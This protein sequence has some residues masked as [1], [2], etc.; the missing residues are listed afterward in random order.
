MVEIL[1]ALVP[2]FVALMVAL[3]DRADRP[4]QPRVG[5]GYGHAHAVRLLLDKF[6]P[7]SD[8]RSDR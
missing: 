2:F 4:A 3:L 7:R 1:A 8:D 5:G 6:R